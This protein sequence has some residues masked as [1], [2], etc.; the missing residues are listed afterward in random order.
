[1]NDVGGIYALLHPY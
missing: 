1:V